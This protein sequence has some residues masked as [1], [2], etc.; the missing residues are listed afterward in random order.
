[1][2]G[3]PSREFRGEAG[4]EAE[5]GLGE[6]SGVIGEHEGWDDLG[7][8][9]E[10]GRSKWGK[11]Q[12]YVSER[13]RSSE[14]EGGL[15]ANPKAERKHCQEKD[16]PVNATRAS[17]EDCQRNTPPADC[18]HTR[19]GSTKRG[20]WSWKEYQRAKGTA[21]ARRRRAE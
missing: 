14:L 10:R 11:A 17:A 8:M 12:G 21:D 9:G 15:G 18:F 5:I 3:G 20:T 6:K 4:D 13:E 2:D 7:S 1:M 19:R 16:G